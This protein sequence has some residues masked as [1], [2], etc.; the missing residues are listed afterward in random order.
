MDSNLNKNIS[1]IFEEIADMLEILDENPFKISAFRNSAR[2]IQNLPSSIDEM[3]KSGDLKNIKGLGKAS[4][5]KISEFILT[6]QIMYH[7]ELSRSIPSGLFDVLRIK[8]LGPKKVKRLWKELDI[9]SLGEL[10]YACKENR[11]ILLNGFGEKTQKNVLE[12]INF[13]KMNSGKHLSGVIFEAIDDFEQFL[14]KH[15]IFDR[16]SPVGYSRILSETYESIDYLFGTDS[17]DKSK[18]ILTKYFSEIIT[19]ESGLIKAVSKS[20]INFYLNFC[21]KNAYPLSLFYYT[22]NLVFFNYL[23]EVF[24]KNNIDS[25][26]DDLRKNNKIIVLNDEADIFYNLGI[27]FI[28]PEL[29]YDPDYLSAAKNYEIPEK[30][31]VSDIKGALHIHTTFS[32]GQDTLEA[33]TI[34]AIKLG[35]E[36]IG[37]C[38]H[39]QSAFYANGLSPERIKQQSDEIDLLQKKY[40]NIKIFKGIESD[41]LKDGSLDYP[42]EILKKFDFIVASIHSNF[43]LS[44]EEMTARLVKT[45]SNKY[46]TILGHPTGRLLLSRESYKFDWDKVISACKTNNTALELNSDEHRL[47][48]PY[49][50]IKK[51]IKE[52]IKISINSDAHRIASLSNIINGVRIIN[53]TLIKKEDVLNSYSHEDF[54]KIIKKTK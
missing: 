19:S 46:T 9:S 17:V 29:R 45:V 39:S 14:A 24:T 50:I 3:L 33:M 4:L 27:Q 47:D 10:E 30:L 40:T 23:S 25:S 36:Y 5:E 6:G 13:L 21:S 43:N 53:K 48:T 35:F 7:R 18:E 32:D 52:G 54:I 11:L 37:F 31:K 15:S 42:D 49:S 28:R 51:A 38:D 2:I 8:G 1:E 22:G 44:Y 20:G 26:P 41:I 12:N 34:N 16:F